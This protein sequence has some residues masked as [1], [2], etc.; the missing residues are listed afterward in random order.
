[1]GSGGETLPR[2]WCDS[3][4]RRSRRRS[5]WYMTTERGL[6]NM[7]TQVHMLS[8]S[9]NKNCVC[10]CLCVCMWI[11]CSLSMPTQW[12][13]YRMIWPEY[14]PG[15][16]RH[17]TRLEPGPA[18]L[19]MIAEAT[20][21]EAVSQMRWQEEP[22]GSLELSCHCHLPWENLCE[23]ESHKSLCKGDTRR[24]ITVLH[25]IMSFYTLNWAVPEPS[26]F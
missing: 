4:Y 25:K 23:K 17:I 7:Q 21:P 18:C 13:L 3:V 2:E 8:S 20:K 12:H 14:F 24:S 22:A 26:D 1:M 10:E 19:G 5:L 9:I 16:V 11:N 6:L 15:S